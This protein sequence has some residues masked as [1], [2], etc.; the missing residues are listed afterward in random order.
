MV[1][2]EVASAPEG[3]SDKPNV[4]VLVRDGQRVLTSVVGSL[5]LGDDRFSSETR[6]NFSISH[7]KANSLTC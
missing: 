1:S 4:A 3:P 2:N 7:S 5:P 6:S